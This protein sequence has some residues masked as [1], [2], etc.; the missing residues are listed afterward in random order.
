MKEG[1]GNAITKIKG[2]A[3]KEET[4]WTISKTEQVSS[5]DEDESQERCQLCVHR[6]CSA[7]SPG[8]VPYGP[9]AYCDDPFS[10]RG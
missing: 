9:G 1:I 10:E 5:N 3:K 8:G 6:S 2:D 4:R 7:S